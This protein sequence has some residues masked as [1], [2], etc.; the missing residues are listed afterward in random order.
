MVVHCKKNYAI[1]QHHQT[2]ITDPEYDDREYKR[3]GNILLNDYRGNIRIADKTHSL[4][5]FT[6]PRWLDDDTSA[7]DGLTFLWISNNDIQVVDLPEVNGR[8]T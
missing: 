8:S 7:T 1:L 5:A 2:Q 4:A 3:L 6:Y